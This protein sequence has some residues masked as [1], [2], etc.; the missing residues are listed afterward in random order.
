MKIVRVCKD[1]TTDQW[2][3]LV[4]S[5][6]GQ[7]IQMKCSKLNPALFHFLMDHFDPH[8]CALDFGDRGRIPVTLDSVVKVLGVSMGNTAVPYTL[9]VDATS[10]ILEMLGIKNGVQPTVTSIDKQL[11]PGFPTDTAYRRKF[12]IYLI[13]SVFAPSTGIEVSPK[14]Y[15]PVIN[16]DAIKTLN[17]AKFVV[18]ILV[19]TANAKDNKNWFKACMPY[20]MILYLD[21]L[22]ISAVDVPEDGTRCCVWTN[23]MIRLVSDLDTY[24]NGN[25]GALQDVEKYRQ[26]VINMCTIFEEGLI[27]FIKSLGA[28]DEKGDTTNSGQPIVVQP[29]LVQNEGNPKRRRITRRKKEDC[30]GIKQ[31]QKDVEVPAEV[32]PDPGKTSDAKDQMYV[33]TDVVVLP[34]A[35]PNCSSKKMKSVDHGMPNDRADKSKVQHTQVE[36]A[37]D[38]QIDTHE[39]LKQLQIYGSGSNAKAE[40]HSS[41]KGEPFLPSSLTTIPQCQEQLHEGNISAKEMIGNSSKKRKKNVSFVLENQEEKRKLDGPIATDIGTPPEECSPIGGRRPLTSSSKDKCCKCGD[42]GEPQVDLHNSM[43]RNLDHQ[44]GTSEDFPETKSQRK[45][46][47]LIEDCPSFDLGFEI[48]GNEGASAVETEV[49]VKETQ[50]LVI[51]SSNEESGDSLDKIYANVEMPVRTPIAAVKSVA[52]DVL[53]TSVGPNISTPIPEA[54]KKMIVKAAQN[55]KS[56]YVECS[57]KEIATKYTNEVYN[58][59]CAY[60]GETKDDLNKNYIIDNGSFFIHLRDLAD[61]VRPG[62]W[63]SNSTCEVALRVLAPDMAD[64]KKHVMPLWVATKLRGVMCIHDR[65]VKKIFK[66]TAENRLDHKEQFNGHYYLIVLN[67]K[68]GRFEVFDSLRAK[69]NRGLQKDYRAII[70]SIKYMWVENY[71]ESKINID[72]WPTVHIDTPMQK[73]S[74]DCGYFMLKFIELWNG[75]KML[76]AINPLEMP[77]I[78][79]Q[80]TLKWLEWSDNIVPWAE[81]LF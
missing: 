62:A 33:K 16:T 48:Q 20:I 60:G 61:S 56:P 64:K 39:A 22:E 63:L 7:I 29:I 43:N 25:F 8:G 4:N 47:E 42:A 69:S 6:L 79:K 30:Q 71:S 57:K 81:L 12:V 70:G 11:G 77:I 46:R 18:D 26:A 21:S 37:G 35:V 65:S 78:K 59:V 2:D 5:D 52:E 55:Q 68:A 72:K 40:G 41:D 36:C 13:S 51:I 23:Q 76:A 74:H 53:V 27:A 19:Q 38:V 54:H 17:W 31:Q 66:C 1:L 3:L 44:F 50:E 15:P 45:R 75:R 80:Y 67:L 73:T 10:L 49:A 34:D 32:V 14:C 58:R 28:T 24:C 9:D